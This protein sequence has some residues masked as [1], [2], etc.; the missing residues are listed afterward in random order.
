MGLIEILFTR[1]KQ[2]TIHRWKPEGLV[3]VLLV[4]FDRANLN[5]GCAIKYHY[6]I[7]SNEVIM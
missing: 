7:D 3:E 5:K 2:I 1:K 4:E 6:V